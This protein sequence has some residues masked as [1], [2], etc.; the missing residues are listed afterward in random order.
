MNNITKYQ[1]LLMKQNDKVTVSDFRRIKSEVAK[2]IGHGISERYWNKNWA[3]GGKIQACCQLEDLIKD[4]KTSSG[5]FAPEIVFSS[6]KKSLR[7]KKV[8]DDE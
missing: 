5:S 2:L 8:D 1:S 7:T 4:A 6:K 3:K